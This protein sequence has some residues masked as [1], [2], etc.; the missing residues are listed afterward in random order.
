[1]RA[2]GCLA[3]GP[4]ALLA[5]AAC[6]DGSGT[7]VPDSDT[8]VAAD[9]TTPDASDAAATDA[10]VVLDADTTASDADAWT[11][12]P[13]RAPGARAPRTARCD[14]MD[15]ARCFLPWPSNAFVVADAARA[16]GL[17][18]SLAADVLPADEGLETLAGADGFS[19]VTPVV[20]ALPAGVTSGGMRL[21]VAEPGA[22][23]G[24]EIALRIIVYP[25]RTE[26]DPA[27]LVGYPLAPLAAASEHLAIVTGIGPASRAALVALGETAPTS[28]DEAA[29]VAYHAPAR[30]LLAAA[31]VDVAPIARVW[32]FTTRSTED[33]LAHLRSM[34]AAAKQ[35]V[36]SGSATVSIDT[37][38]VATE[39]IAAIV[40]GH[41][42]GLPD[43]LADGGAFRVPFRVV[44]P[45]G[46]GDYR[47][48]MYGHG[49][50]GDVHDS[51]FDEL[52]AGSGAAKVNVEIDGW[53][54]DTVAGALSG[55]LVPLVGTDAL[56][57]RMRRALAGIAAI[58]QAL[59]G[60]LGDALAADTVLG[61]PNP[62]A[63]RR[64]RTD[65]PIWAGGSLG[66]VIGMVY[67]HLE[68]SIVGGLLNVPGAGFTHWLG[69]SSLS[70]LLD[71]ALEGRYPA[72]VDQ[73]L[74][75]AMAQTSWDEVDGA[76]WAGTRATPPVFLVQMS[77]GDP[78]MPN[79]ATA[80]VATS[81]G[82]VM[83]APDGATPLVPVAGLSQATE[84][85]GRTA[86]CEFA[87]VP[88]SASSIHGFAAGDSPAGQAARAQL[89]AFVATL[90]ADDPVITIPDACLPLDP[91]GLCDFRPAD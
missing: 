25:G 12:P 22:D 27:V 41:I 61:A 10:T 18:L 87:T 71:L 28:G 52:I 78:I 33:P 3:V 70:E 29:L 39:P 45:S 6:T 90:W 56:V 89:I 32:D 85:R 63:G 21:F 43:P 8:S 77:V 48:V 57:A 37:L 72:M 60:P 65:H 16:T 69:Q 15:P 81:L 30:A 34:A 64:P 68:P 40:V 62:A 66:G 74:A 47:I 14:D 2:C 44:V 73:Q 23:Y 20:A 83:L 53:T 4:V 42:D 84:A 91:P 9:T 35:A 5:W 86:L 13:D 31:E 17:R 26:A 11:T 36:D 46:D 54:G 75:A 19:R 50:G 59:G 49:T 55:L 76:V 24:R 1:M 79:I 7:N 38:V 82:A 51:A 67:G 80:L 58:Q 88:G